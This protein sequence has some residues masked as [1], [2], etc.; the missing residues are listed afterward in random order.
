MFGN[1]DANSLN[2]S[3]AV[4]PGYLCRLLP[5]TLL[6][7][8]L[9]VGLPGCGPSSVGTIPVE[10][11][12]STMGTYYKITLTQL[13]QN[14]SV[15]QL[16]SEID[17]RLETVND[18]M[19]TWRDYSELSRFNT[20]T[21]TGWF[22]VSEET[23]LVLAEA[24]RISELSGGAFDVTVGPLINLW[25]F[26]E[27][28]GTDR[29]P[30]DEEITTAKQTIGYQQFPLAST[31][32]AARVLF[33]PVVSSHTDFRFRSPIITVKIGSLHKLRAPERSFAQMQRLGQPSLNV[34]SAETPRD[35]R[36]KSSSKGPL[37]Q[38]DA[39]ISYEESIAKTGRGLS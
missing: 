23:A 11:S 10:I 9:L 19:S 17:A 34:R 18:Q 27:Q 26:G 24:N 4:C 2:A 32:L 37:R 29:I 30:T 1:C 13:P 5:F 35:L 36:T 12:G 38:L 28:P 22:E 16:Q 39:R 15:D 8:L 33:S 6:L 14:S 21:G 7:V 3:S 31:T 25:N 20:Q